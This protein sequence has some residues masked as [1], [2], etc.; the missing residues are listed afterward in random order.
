MVGKDL[1][2]LEPVPGSP[3]PLLFSKPARLVPVLIGVAIGAEV[4]SPET[5]VRSARDRDFVAS[6]LSPSPQTPLHAS[7]ARSAA[8]S[9]RSAVS[10]PSVNPTPET[11]I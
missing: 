2:H 6:L 5:R 9:L 7:S 8:A 4:R 10:K 1:L 11:A 3:P